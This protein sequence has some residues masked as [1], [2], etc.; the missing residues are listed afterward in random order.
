[1]ENQEPRYAKG[2]KPRQATMNGLLGEFSEK[3]PT[4]AQKGIQIYETRK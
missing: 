1:M 3:P 2:Q 4:Q